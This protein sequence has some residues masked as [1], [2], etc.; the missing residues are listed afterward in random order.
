MSEENI[1]SSAAPTNDG[2]DP[3]QSPPALPDNVKD[4]IGPGKKYASVEKALEALGHAQSHIANIEAENKSFREKQAG[5]LTLEEVNKTVQDLLAAERATHIPA[6]VDEATLSGLLDR[7]LA[8]KTAADLKV[9]NQTSV[10]EAMR[11]K[12]G[13]KAQEMYETKAKEL[14]VGVAFLNDVSA[15]S[16]KAA[17]ELFGLVPKASSV[18]KSSGSINTD[19]LNQTPAA[20]APPKSPMFGGTSKDIQAS[21]DYAKQQVLKRNNGG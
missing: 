11:A 8:Q 1:F 6:V 15:A 7:K 17:L 18:P 19:A 16:P 2:G 10:V 3:A 20:D 14:G 21:W 9:A 4:L 13:D 5:Q 12:Y